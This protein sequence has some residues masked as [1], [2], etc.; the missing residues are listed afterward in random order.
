[1]RN[2]LDIFLIIRLVQ[3]HMP[4]VRW[5]Q[6]RVSHPGADDDG[7][8]FFWI[9]GYPGDVQLESWNGMLPFLAETDKHDERVMCN[10]AEDAARVVCDWLLLP[11]GRAESF[12]YDRRGS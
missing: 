8:W 2:D 7:I 10:S 5:T 12:W 1:M 9:P 4:T 11:G 6:L 3:E